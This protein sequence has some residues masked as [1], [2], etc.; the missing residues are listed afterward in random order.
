M[1]VA[2]IGHPYVVDAN[3]GKWRC[4]KSLGVE[5]TLI[6]PDLW[7]ERD[8]GPRACD[9]A[10]DLDIVSLP[11]R[12][13]GRV[14]RYRF[15]WF[16]LARALDRAR[17]DI[18]HVEAE[19]GAAVALQARA[20]KCRG[21]RLTQFCWEN[22]PIADRTRRWAARLNDS[23]VDHLFCGTRGALEVARVDGRR[24]EAS[25]A[26]QIGVD[27]TAVEE[28]APTLEREPGVFLIGFAGRLDAKKG[29]DVLLDAMESIED[30][31]CRLAILGDG[32]ERDRWGE[33][34]RASR[35]ER[36]VSFHAAVPHDA[37]PGFIRSLD[38]LVLPSRT[39]PGWREQFGHVLI[40]AMAARVPVIGSDSGAIPEVIGDAGVVT[41]E[42]DATALAA[43]LRALRVDPDRRR[44][45]GER[46]RRRVEE[47][48]TD[49]AIAR[50]L[51]A[52]WERWGRS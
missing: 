22:I 41:P 16:S 43:A 7:L 12:D 24:G 2:V 35:L 33:R 39:R 45:L 5:P 38:V 17:P 50:A 40:L 44:D 31:D 46:G 28:A 15:E 19:L 47:R 23:G 42:G 29:V 10:D 48:Y 37:V 26:A 6:A 30:P 13:S 9:P 20:L 18:V 27:L 21:F 3:R 36:R 8:F 32:P 49:D 4:L 11:I 1:R 25:V 14:R 34:A 52:V 51:L